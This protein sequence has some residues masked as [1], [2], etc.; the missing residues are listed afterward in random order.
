M[1]LTLE[2]HVWQCVLLNMR[3][4]ILEQMIR[5]SEILELSVIKAKL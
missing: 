3:F 2:T 4:Y 5:S 1:Q